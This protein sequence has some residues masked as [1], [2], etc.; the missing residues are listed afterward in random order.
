MFG[1]NRVFS[2]KYLLGGI[3]GILLSFLMCLPSL[4]EIALPTINVGMQPANSPREFSQGIQILIMLTVLTLAPSILIMTTSFTRI[5]IVLSLTRQAIG[6]SSL[7]PTQV[8]ISL[9]LILTFFIMAPTFNKINETAFQPYLNNKITQEEALSRSMGPMR[10]FM[11]KYAEE[12]EL[13]LFVKM[14]KIE[15]PKNKDDI[16]TY[17]LLPSFIISELKTAFK[18]GFMIFIPFLVIDIVVSSILV[19]MGMLF[20]PPAIIA[21][22]FKII[23]FVL[24]DGWYLVTKSLLE[25]FMM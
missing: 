1:E 25:G 5:V 7:P 6:T 8:I 14:S 3:S 15:K 23:L 18:I 13:A 9:A 16:P 19:A 11:F 20:L 10:D 2:L 22:P 12:K 17:V 4:A 24:I 21:T